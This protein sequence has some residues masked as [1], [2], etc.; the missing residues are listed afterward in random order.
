MGGIVP[1]AELGYR[2]RFG[3]LRSTVHAAFAAEEGSDFD[4]VSAAEKRGSLLAGLSLGGK[5]G[6]VDLRAGYQGVFDGN[7]TS[8]SANVRIVMPLGGR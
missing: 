1:E 8:H 2:H 7:A 6:P 5:V 3:D 4:A